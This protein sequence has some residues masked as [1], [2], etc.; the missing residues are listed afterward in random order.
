MLHT[1]IN[2]IW[3]WR[4]GV[5]YRTITGVN[6]PLVILDNVKVRACITLPLCM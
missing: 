5:D 3:W 2:L 6:G 1:L 4:Y